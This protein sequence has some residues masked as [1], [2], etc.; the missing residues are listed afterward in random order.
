MKVKLITLPLSWAYHI[1]QFDNVDEVKVEESEVDSSDLAFTDQVNIF[2]NSKRAAQRVV[3][4]IPPEGKYLFTTNDGWRVHQ[5]A[6][7]TD[8][9]S[10]M[11]AFTHKEVTYQVGWSSDAQRLW[12]RKNEVDLDME[13]DLRDAYVQLRKLFPKH[14]YKYADAALREAALQAR[15]KARKRLL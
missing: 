9:G 13:T 15:N 6:P 2:K 3:A 11:L 5:L 10:V 12:S 7:R 4:N 1:V 14:G 8:F